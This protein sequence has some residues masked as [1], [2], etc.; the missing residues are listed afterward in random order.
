METVNSI[1]KCFSEKHR[2]KVFLATAT[3]FF[4]AIT[5]PFYPIIWM[6][7]TACNFE[8]NIALGQPRCF[9]HI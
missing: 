7:K 9:A 2:I 1:N 5:R 4:Q 8:Q 3:S 6:R